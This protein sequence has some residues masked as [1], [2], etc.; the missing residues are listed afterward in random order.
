MIDYIF[1]SKNLKVKKVSKLYSK[2][3]YNRKNIA[4]NKNQPSDHFILT[5]TVKI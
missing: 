4:P 5:A 2:S 1:T 3:H